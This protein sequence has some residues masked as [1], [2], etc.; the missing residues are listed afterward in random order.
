MSILFT[1]VCLEPS[2]APGIEQALIKC[3]WIMKLKATVVQNWETKEGTLWD[4]YD[5]SKD[6]CLGDC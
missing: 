6:L 5:V 4:G 1:T 2:I 3:F